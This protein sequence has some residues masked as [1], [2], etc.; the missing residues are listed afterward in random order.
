MSFCV[1]LLIVMQNFVAI[2]SAVLEKMSLKLLFWVIL[3]IFPSWNYHFRRSVCAARCDVVK[4]YV[5]QS[6]RSCT[7]CKHK[8]R[9][10]AQFWIELAAPYTLANHNEINSNDISPF[11][12]FSTPVSCDGSI[13]LWRQRLLLSPLPLWRHKHTLFGVIR[14]LTC[15]KS[16]TFRESLNDIFFIDISAFTA[17]FAFDFFLYIVFFCE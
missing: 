14:P 13:R 9:G 17:C 15:G 6:Y 5:L 4:P 8:T 2:R 10:E 11:T 16:R 1:I 7:F 3:Q 12:I